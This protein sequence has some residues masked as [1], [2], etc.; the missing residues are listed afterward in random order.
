MKVE[1]MWVLLLTLAVAAGLGYITRPKDPFAPRAGE[2]RGIDVSAH[3]K[4]IDWSRVANE[5]VEFAYLKATEG[6]D[7]VDEQFAR[8]WRGAG[9]AGIRRGAYHFY[10]LRRSG[11]EQAD[12][13]LRTVPPD[14]EA[15][16][17]VVDLEFAGNS[18]NPPGRE[19]LIRELGIFIQRVEGAWKRPVIFYL[20]SN[21]QIHYQVRQAFDR[22]IWIS[23]GL[24]RPSKDTWRVW[25]FTDR[26]RVYGIEGDVDLDLM[27]Y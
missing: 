24:E 16:P 7:W 3:Q 26:G 23:K 12:N 25:Q 10:T 17:P 15:L 8:N 2:H 11:S 6:G 19:V 1:R 27:K 18:V 13:F 21:F 5:G 20:A 9:L 22:E 14:G 4:D